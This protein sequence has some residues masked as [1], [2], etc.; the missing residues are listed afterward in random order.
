M[1]TAVDLYARSRVIIDGY[2]RS[3]VEPVVEFCPPIPGAAEKGMVEDWIAQAVSRIDT[4][5][6]RA[7]PARTGHSDR[8]P[9]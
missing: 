8:K 2:G 3:E 5:R 7:D 6:R 1:E 9:A 4:T